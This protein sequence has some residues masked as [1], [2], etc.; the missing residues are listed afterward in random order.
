MWE[1]CHAPQRHVEKRTLQERHGNLLNQRQR[2]QQAAHSKPQPVHEGRGCGC[3]LHT[4]GAAYLPV[5]C[6]CVSLTYTEGLTLVVAP[7]GRSSMLQGTV[8]TWSNMHAPT[9]LTRS[10]GAGTSFIVIVGN[11][12]HT[13]STSA[14]DVRWRVGLPAYPSTQQYKQGVR[15][16]TDAMSA[17]WRQ[18]HTPL[19]Y[20]VVAV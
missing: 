11:A 9:V 3:F 1:G 6:A 15:S 19:T 2:G 7:P 8:N 4:A 18:Q 17:Q 16:Q 20:V 5:A 10:S 13:T 14:S 12:S